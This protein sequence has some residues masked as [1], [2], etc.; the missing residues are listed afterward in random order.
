MNPGL[1][2]IVPTFNR[3]SFIPGLIAS[4]MSAGVQNLEIVIVDDGS[5]DDTESVVRAY[6]PPVMYARQDNA[7][8]AVARNL[9][10]SVSRGAYVTFLDSDDSWRPAAFR[11]FFA[12]VSSHAELPCVFGDASMGNPTDGFVSFVRTYGRDAFPAVP[13]KPIDTQLRL[14][15]RWPF[16]RTMVRR[17]VIFLGSLIVRRDV[18]DTVGGFNPDLRGAADWELFLR[19][20]AAYE[21]AWW[22][23]EPVCEY[24]KHPGGMSTDSEHMEHEFSRALASVRNRCELPDG[25]REFVRHR[26]REQLFGMAYL[27]YD[28]GDLRTARQ[29]LWGMQQQ[30]FAGAR[31]WMYFLLTCMPPSAVNVVRHAKH[32]LDQRSAP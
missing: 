23:G 30:G 13:A 20:A 26:L 8:P 11:A 9:G 1:S 24:L 32:S 21:M 28:R 12:A 17:N 4:L 2:V 15:D 31:E 29:R 27:A 5:L 18:F 19:L 16:F 14:L 22:T 25:E 3:A 10:F 6:G 7:G